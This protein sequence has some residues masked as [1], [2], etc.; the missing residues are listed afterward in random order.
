MHD[1]VEL[2]TLLIAR[3]ACID[4]PD[5]LWNSTPLGWANYMKRQKAEAYLR[6][7]EIAPSSSSSFCLIGMPPA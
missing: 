7:Y 2:M 6:A 4:T 5:T 3:G 1:D